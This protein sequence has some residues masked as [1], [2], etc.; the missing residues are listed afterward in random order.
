METLK[1]WWNFIF[2]RK[3]RSSVRYGGS[4][5]P[6][7]NIRFHLPP[8]VDPYRTQREE[9]ISEQQIDTTMEISLVDN[10]DFSWEKGKRLL[11]KVE[12][13]DYMAGTIANTHYLCR[14]R[15]QKGGRSDQKYIT[16]PAHLVDVFEGCGNWGLCNGENF[17]QV[18]AYKFTQA[19]RHM[20][21]WRLVMEPPT[22]GRIE[23]IQL[24]S[25]ERTYKTVQL[26]LSYAGS[27]ENVVVL[28]DMYLVRDFPLSV[29]K[30]VV[31]TTLGG[32]LRVTGMFHPNN[33]MIQQISSRKKKFPTPSNEDFEYFLGDY[34]YLNDNGE[35][36]GGDRMGE[37]VDEDEQ[38]GYDEE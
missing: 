4:H 29:G 9:S 26:H 7:G 18:E 31:L 32:R 11:V 14:F 17:V 30:Y 24:V 3:S 36:D 1:S 19:D 37:T 2:R 27:L 5:R 38:F 12:N 23:H 33:K 25:F 13:L 6:D 35:F 21:R 20:E 28:A 8:S 15:S 10:I 22:V 16:V 34:A